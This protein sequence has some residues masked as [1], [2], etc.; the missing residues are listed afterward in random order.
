M[1]VVEYILKGDA[2]G[3]VSAFSSTGK[4]AGI[5]TTAFTL[6]TA[7]SVK[8]G[9]ATFNLIQET[10][11]LRNELGDLA[12]QTALSAETLSGLR[13]AASASDESLGSLAGGLRKFAKN[14]ADTRDGTGEAKDAFAALGVEV[15][16]ADGSLRNADDVFRETIALLQQETND[17]EKAALATDLFGRSGQKLAQVLGDVPLDEFNERARVFG[18][19]TGPEAIKS[20][21]EW[22]S[23]MADFNLVTEATTGIIADAFSFSAITNIRIL[24]DGFALLSI[25]A[26]EMSK[27]FLDFELA[28]IR[29][30]KA[31]ENFSNDAA[32][33]RD[34]WQSALSQILPDF[35]EWEGVI[36]RIATRFNDLKNTGAVESAKDLRSEYEKLLDVGGALEDHAGPMQDFFFDAAEA[37]RENARA[38]RELEEARR[39]QVEAAMEAEQQL[40][41]FLNGVRLGREA[42]VEEEQDAKDEA[43]AADRKRQSDKQKQEDKDA[44]EEKKRILTRE[45]LEKELQRSI[46][47]TLDITVGTLQ[48]LGLEA[49]A[50]YDVIFVAAK[51]AAIAGVAIDTGRAIMAALAFGGPLGTAAAIAAAAEGAAQMANIVATSIGGGGNIKQPSGGGPSAQDL[52][53]QTIA[54]TEGLEAPGDG[55]A[56]PWGGVDDGGGRGATVIMF[57]HELYDVTIPDSVRIPGSAF[58]RVQKNGARVGQ[59]TGNASPRLLLRP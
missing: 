35:T 51:A 29:V 31:I 3:A 40:D 44:K 39:A 43:D 36:G 7:A 46:I 11:N 33:I 6:L 32:A 1:P 26:D 19:D 49:T 42:G 59:R 52:G 15:A 20:A 50:A 30:D 25:T 12:G 22:Q 8:A 38:L 34:A 4:A 9:K 57:R 2:K 16:N 55:G 37:A 18:I 23:A 41:D 54:L 48:Q 14:M 21:Q 17:T 58:S 10:V 24:T 28:G 56:G 27:A 47:A 53:A 45:D 13:V 5:A